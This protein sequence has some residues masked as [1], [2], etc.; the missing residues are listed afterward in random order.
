MPCSLACFLLC[1]VV[2]ASGS[3]AFNDR[4]ELRAALV[5]W[6]EG[7]TSS[8]VAKYGEIEQW[9]VSRVTNFSSLFEDLASFNEDIGH[10]DTSAVTT[11]SRAFSGAAAFNQPIAC[12][13]MSQVTDMS[14]TEYCGEPTTRVPTHA[15]RAVGVQPLGARAPPS[16]K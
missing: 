15:P 14:W 12:W 16:A 7:Q 3:R 9:D 8:L 5:A 11:M 1:L 10:W 13:N 4:T 2:P 6:E